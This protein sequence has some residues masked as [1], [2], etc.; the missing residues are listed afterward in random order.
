MACADFDHN[1]FQTDQISQGEELLRSLEQ[2]TEHE[3]LP[4]MGF[5]YIYFAQND[6]DKAYNWLERAFE[7]K[8]S[9]LPWCA[10]IPVKGYQVS[11]E[12][13]LRPVFKKYGLIK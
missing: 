1:L 3:Y 5:S 11:K 12:P 6:L 8:D 7:E 2:R 13:R 10:I 4:P 9:F